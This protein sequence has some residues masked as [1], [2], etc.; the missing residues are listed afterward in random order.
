VDFG[1]IFVVLGESGVC[2]YRLSVS[3]YSGDAGDALAATVTPSTRLNG[4]RFSTPDVDNDNH[5][6]R[7]ITG[8]ALMG[9]WENCCARSTINYDTNGDWN[10]ATAAFI[11]DVTDARMMVKLD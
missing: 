2:F 7:C 11:Q 8:V 9:W 3:G 6:T 5:P 1:G 4:I 10:A